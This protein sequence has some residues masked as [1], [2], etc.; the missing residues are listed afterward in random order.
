MKG[1]QMKGAS[2]GWTTTKAT[3]AT[4]VFEGGR[5]GL[6]EEIAFVDN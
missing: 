2:R 4:G 5:Q 6:A 3:Y 1:V